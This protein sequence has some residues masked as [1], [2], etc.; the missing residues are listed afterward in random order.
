MATKPI[1][2]DK[3]S[4]AGSIPK[5]QEHKFHSVSL[6]S[7]EWSRLPRVGGR[8]PSSG[9]SRSALIDLGVTV[10]GLVVRL[11]KPGAIRGAVLLHL[12]TLRQYLRDMRESQL[13]GGA[14]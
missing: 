9:L 12:P 8:D 1:Q 11:R 4:L 3:L 6:E 10:P 5:G 14:Q 2:S 13:K 7:A